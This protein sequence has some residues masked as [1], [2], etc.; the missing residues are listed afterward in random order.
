MPAIL[1]PGAV[2]WADLNGD[3]ATDLL[4]GDSTAAEG[5]ILRTVDLGSILNS[6]ASPNMLVAISNGI[7]SVTLIGYVSSTKFSLEDAAMGRPWPD[8]MPFPVQVIGSLTI[9]DS[10][11]HQY[12]TTFRYHDAYYDPVEKQF[13]GLPAPSK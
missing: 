7:G 4:Y 13:A 11:G 5:E 3:G 8:P 1:T 12:V 6:G 10:L 2:R 9:L